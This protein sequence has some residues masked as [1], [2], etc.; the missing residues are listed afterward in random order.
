MK[1][2]IKITDGKTWTDE[3]PLEFEIEEA[4][5]FHQELSKIFRDESNPLD[6]YRNFIT[7]RN[8]D[9]YIKTDTGSWPCLHDGEKPGTI[10]GLSCSCPKCS[11]RS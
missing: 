3:N 10:S 8:E 9:N 2:T 11:P 6:W 1:V 7:P 5:V 4:K